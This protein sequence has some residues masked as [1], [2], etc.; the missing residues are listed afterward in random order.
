M[1]KYDNY[2]AFIYMRLSKDDKLIE[3]E[4]ITNQRELIHSFC[5]QNKIRVIGEF[6][7]DGRTGI[8]FDRPG[9]A[10]MIASLDRMEPDLVITKDLS[11]LGRDMTESSYYAEQF[12]PNK[13][14][15]Y[16][17]IHDH[18]DSFEENMFAP[19]L[20]AMNDVYVRDTS[21]K[22]K[23]VLHQKKSSGQYC[24][25]PPFGYRKS[26]KDKN[27]LV[28]DEI[29]A[30]IVK[31]IFEL[32][33][34]GLSTRKIADSL[35]ADGVITPLKYRVLYRDDF[36]EKG[37]NKATDL[38]NFVT[39]KRII[40]N[41]VYLGHTMLGKTKKQSLKSSMK[42][43]VPKAEWYITENTHEP[44]V[45]LD[46]FD[47]AND[48]L[49]KNWRDYSKSVSRNDGVRAS[50]FRGLVFCQNCG[51]S[52]PS[53]GSVYNKDG[54]SYWYLVCSNIPKRSR[55]HCEH[56]A[57]I[58][59]QDLIDI[60]TKD[61][62]AVIE[63][64]DEQIDRIL[65]N[66]KNDDAT[67]RHN[68]FIRKQCDAIRT[69]IETSNRVIEKL[70]LDNVTG[71]ISNERLDSLMSNITEK[72]KTQESTLCN[73]QSQMIQKED[74]SER[75]LKF[76]E[77]VKSFSKIETLTPEILHAFIDRIEIGEKSIKNARIHQHA[78]QDIKIYYK[79]IGNF[80]AITDESAAS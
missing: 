77:V 14:I 74:M 38:W 51:G 19:F 20:F 44:L 78:T 6:F 33:A 54:K 49:N 61:I 76:F 72:L 27:V 66:I 46:L 12:F 48:T 63:L 47:R 3:S 37:A 16:L 67:A 53:G 65:V 31:R 28:P 7:D 26:D 43:K 62:N 22:I 70:Y 36:S 13:G 73:L 41:P 32:S 60:I 42:V 2:T 21:R 75:Y 52:M 15:C 17:A 18:F 79:F 34:S 35:T 59:Y 25:C 24:A 29:T 23:A 50:I 30:P 68:D 58:R 4:S 8:N 64:T 39:V 1:R 5:L 11:R 45:D 9:F 57:R 10:E 55:H 56:G 69:E 71:K 80:A 40:K